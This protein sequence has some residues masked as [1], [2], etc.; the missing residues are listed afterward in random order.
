MRLLD[1]IAAAVFGA[2]FTSMIAVAWTGPTQAPPN[3]NVAAPINVGS[4]DQVKN[5]GLA[6][7]SLGVFGNSALLGNVGIST[8]DPNAKLNV[9]GTTN[10]SRDNASECCS[11]GNYTLSLA[12]GTSWT[13]RAARIQ[14]H[15]AG[16]SEGFIQLAPSGVRRIIF[17]DNQGVG[18]GIEAS[19][20]IQSN[21]GGFR[22]PD[23]TVQTTAAEGDGSIFSGTLCGMAIVE[24]NSSTPPPPT[25]T[26]FFGGTVHNWSSISTCNGADVTS[27]CPSGYTQKTWQTGSS[28]HPATYSGSITT[29]SEYTTYS[30][31]RSCAKN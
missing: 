3:G 18:L 5:G 21:S 2:V 11:G 16:A 26:T 12:E 19:G 30:F 24:S 22:F 25:S 20:M 6:L 1:L 7:N 28:Y 13:G 14:F 17:G 15:N 29:A 4:T 31:S 9:V 8:T 27:S 10:L 23:G